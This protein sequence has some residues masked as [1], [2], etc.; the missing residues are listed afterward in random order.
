MKTIGFWVPESDLIQRHKRLL[1]TISERENRTFQL[2][3]KYRSSEKTGRT[4]Q[5][6]RAKNRPVFGFY[7]FTYR[8]KF[9]QAADPFKHHRNK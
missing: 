7:P 5:T 3:V 4:K 9:R 1:G 2:L 6:K 8:L